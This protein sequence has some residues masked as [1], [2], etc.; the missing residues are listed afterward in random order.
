[1]AQENMAA[2][3]HVAAAR[4]P[5]SFLKR[6]WECGNF[7]GGSTEP[8]TLSLLA[9]LLHAIGAKRVLECGAYLGHGTAWLACALD[10]LG[11][12]ALTTIELDG[13]RLRH[14]QEL[15]E[16]RIKPRTAITYVQGDVLAALSTFEDNSFDFAFIDDDHTA[17]H[18]EQEILAVLPLV[19]P[20]G[21][22]AVHDVCGSFDHH[23]LIERFGGW[24]LDL[25][26]LHAA[27]GLGLIQV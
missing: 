16:N 8:W 21:L 12:G 1:M 22:I 23:V 14:A 13:V 24:V 9:S 11:G 10:E 27:G 18:V 15:I 19:R 20:G 6:E 5:H 7:G 4:F 2:Q 3:G 26:R 25:P 17:P